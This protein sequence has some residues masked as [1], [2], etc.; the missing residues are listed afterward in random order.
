MWLVLKHGCVIENT[1][2]PCSCSSAGSAA[3]SGSISAMSISAMLQTRASKRSRPSAASWPASAAS[4][5]RYSIPCDGRARACSSI[6]ADA[7]VATTWAPRLASRRANRPFPQAISS[8]V[9][10]ATSPSSRSTAGR[11]SCRWKL[12]PSAPIASSQNAA[13][14]SQRSTASPERWE[15]SRSSA[16][17]P[18]YCVGWPR[19]FDVAADAYDRYMGR[20]AIPLAPR[21]AEF[22]GVRAGQHVLDVGAGP[23][24][25]T[26][27]LAGIVG[28]A[29]VT[30]VD[31]SQ[32]FVAANRERHPGI[33]ALE[34]SA[35]Q[36]P[37]GDDSFDAALAQLV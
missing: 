11:I 22:A 37:F 6:C 4:S 13:L 32:P 18:C 29:L 10:P 7:S 21:F 31:P 15:G 3:A 30:A 17:A 28:A 1:K 23:G 8:T 19:M 16:T 34:A 26:G 2:R 12:F 9:W 27:V 14:R 36:L 33:E 25:L 5:D 35:E 20:Y 24:A